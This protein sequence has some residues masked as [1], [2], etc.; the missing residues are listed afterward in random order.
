MTTIQ[1]EQIIMGSMVRHSTRVTGDEVSVFN[2][3]YETL[4]SYC[5][6]PRGKNPEWDLVC[7]ERA[8]SF[9]KGYHAGRFADGALDNTILELGH[10]LGGIEPA[11]RPRVPK[12]RGKRRV[13]HVVTAVVGVGGHTRTIK[14]WIH[15][16]RSSQHLVV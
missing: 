8:A 10:E 13:L 4:V 5:D 14:N 2:D 7:V 12:H 16:D 15:L 6:H 1:R 9:A 11:M 3:L